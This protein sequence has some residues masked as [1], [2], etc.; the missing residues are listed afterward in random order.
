ME[1]LDRNQKIAVGV[2]AAA[3]VLGGAYYY[4][5]KSGYGPHEDPE[6]AAS[7]Y[8]SK[9]QAIARKQLVSNVHFNHNLVLLKGKI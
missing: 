1:K 3:L 5:T 7:V 8:L 2:G 6:Y 4:F 9:D